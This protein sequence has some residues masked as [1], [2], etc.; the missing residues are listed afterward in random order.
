MEQRRIV[1]RKKEK[2]ILSKP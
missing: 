2:Q 1:F